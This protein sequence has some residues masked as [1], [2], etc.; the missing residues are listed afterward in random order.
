MYCAAEL[1]APGKIRLRRFRRPRP[2][3]NQVLLRVERAGVCGTD[4]AIFT[5]TLK[6]QLP[7]VPGH[8]F[9]SRVE[10]V[11]EGVAEDFIGRL[12]AVEI[13]NTCLAWRR[14]HPCVACRRGLSN[15][16]VDHTVVG[17]H[18]WPGAFAELL[19]VPSG[20]VHVLPESLSPVQG[21]FVEPLAA[22]IQT[23]ELTPLGPFSTV[24]V[25]GAGRLGTLII[26]VAHHLGARVIAVARTPERQQRAQRYGAALA[27]APSPDLASTIKSLT[28]GLGADVVVEA[29]GTSDG[30]QTAL[31]LVRPRGTVALK[32]TCGTLSPQVDTT[33]VAVD[34][35]R[36]Q[37]SRCGPFPK[38]IALLASGHLDVEPLISE[39]LPLA[40]VSQALA[41]A[42]Q[43]SKN[44][45][46]PTR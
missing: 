39:V 36:L 33:R 43:V 22:A 35:V 44:L 45:I 20:G 13:N 21:V 46:D 41:T 31:T 23:F 8:E 15:H 4:V 14:P 1:T 28:A 11:G 5:G 17:I 25:L 24:V 37:G 26:A 34:E 18:R 12:V 2:G 27:L 30:L 3:P 38:A 10:A 40:K 6:V 19:L 32:T 9:C 29:T 7:L 16:C 42:H